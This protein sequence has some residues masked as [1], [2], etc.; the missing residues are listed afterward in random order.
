MT[1]SLLAMDSL[2]ALVWSLIPA[3][4]EAG[5]VEMAFYRSGVAVQAK[6][7]NSPV[8]LADQAAEKVLLE[9]LARVAPGIA[10]VAEEAVSEG[11]VPKIGEEFFLVDPLDG[12][13]EFINN[14]D[15]FT[16]NVALIQRGVPVMG[17][18]YA[19]AIDDFY[20]TLGPDE[21][22]R[23][24][25]RPDAKPVDLAACG[26]ERITTRVGDIARL[27]AVGSRSHMTKET[28]D[29]LARSATAERRDSGSSLKFCAIARGEADIYPRLAHHGMGYGCRLRRPAGCR[30]HS[31]GSR[32]HAFSLRQG[33]RRV[34][35]RPFRRLGFA[36]TTLGEGH[37]R[38]C[39][40]SVLMRGKLAQS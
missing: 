9:A 21:A 8:T 37:T 24:R 10:V 14:R 13:R 15:E 35:Q 27:T 1:S 16:V 26:F 34:P 32:W 3:V 28:E 5:A 2:R 7:D 31:H 29:F 40:A 25:F 19:P 23:A 39:K 30:G 38:P 4:L 18:V 17:I 33:G 36:Q 11:K 22:V 12:T 20:A 6:A